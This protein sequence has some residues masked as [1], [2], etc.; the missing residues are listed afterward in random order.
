MELPSRNS[1]RFPRYEEYESSRCLSC[2]NS[3]AIFLTIM[4]P[5]EL[6][7]KASSNVEN[8]TLPRDLISRSSL[9]HVIGE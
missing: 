3:G 8:A 4:I 2:T 1:G 6:G 9:E 5:K 7:P